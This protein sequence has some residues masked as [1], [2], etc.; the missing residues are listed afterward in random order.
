MSD[1]EPSLTITVISAIPFQ[2]T[3]GVNV[4]VSLLTVAIT[5]VVSDEAE[6][7]KVSPSVSVADKMISLAVSSLIFP[8]TNE[9]RDGATLL[10]PSGDS[11][12]SGSKSSPSNPHLLAK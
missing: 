12:S 10:F 4:N 9:P 6:Y 5:A 2:L 1:K 7:V 8:S 3:S 11:P